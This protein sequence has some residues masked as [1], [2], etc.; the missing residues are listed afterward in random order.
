MR[1]LVLLSLSLALSACSKDASPC[2]RLY[3]HW[4]STARANVKEAVEASKPIDR[5]H[6]RERG[7]RE[8]AHARSR[9][10]QVCSRF[11]SIDLEC[12]QG[13]DKD[14]DRACRD[15]RERF[16]DQVYAGLD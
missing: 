2:D 6:I 16:Y 9:F 4:L 1:W 11:G 7:E 3:D 13:D 8:I 5:A 12:F 15:T 10:H 14:K